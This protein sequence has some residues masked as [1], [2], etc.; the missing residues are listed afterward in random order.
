MAADEE[1]YEPEKTVVPRQEYGSAPGAVRPEYAEP[2]ALPNEPAGKKEAAGCTG[3][4]RDM[5]DVFGILLNP[6]GAETERKR[7]FLQV[8][9]FYCAEA[10]VSV[11]FQSIVT[12]I[13]ALAF[14][15]FASA[16][17][18]AHL[19][20]LSSAYRANAQAGIG[21]ISGSG[22]TLLG[23]AMSLVLLYLV[24]LVD[25]LVYGW[26]YHGIGRLL[27]WFK[28]S[29]G[30]T[31]SAV[32]YSSVPLLLL[33]L[34][35]GMLILFSFS[36]SISSGI[37]TYILVIVMLIVWALYIFLSSIRSLQGT[38]MWPAIAL[39]IIAAIPAIIVNGVIVGAIGLAFGAAGTSLGLGSVF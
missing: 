8:L 13:M 10:V 12:L 36:T 37:L 32:A 29:I 26:V 14:G 16:A 34:P 15:Y 31:L 17:N 6:A 38:T 4:I 19:L 20:S 28:G 33:T 30:A 2:A 35:A 18:V 21:G 5:R 24:I 7:S 27:G 23:S 39:W 9:R 3:F 25:I 11:V 22:V 1:Y